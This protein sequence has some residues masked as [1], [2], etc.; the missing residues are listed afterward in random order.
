MA[1]VMA[2]AVAIVGSEEAA[3]AWEEQS[4]VPV[5][6]SGAM[7]SPGDG[8]RA[9]QRPRRRNVPSDP[10]V[11]HRGLCPCS[12]AVPGL[13]R[14]P[15]TSWPLVRPGDSL[16]FLSQPLGVG[17]PFWQPPPGCCRRCWAGRTLRGDVRRRA[18]QE[19]P[20]R[21][22]RV[23]PQRADVK[24][25]L[26]TSGGS[27]E[28][29]QPKPWLPEPRGRY[30]PESWGSRPSQ[31]GWGSGGGGGGAPITPSRQAE[32]TQRANGW[33]S[34]GFPATPRASRCCHL[35]SLVFIF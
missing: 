21:S 14:H 11:S 32:F 10:E 19:G 7:T 4:R 17:S 27:T 34:V 22:A 1:D 6:S 2:V 30:T 35:S 13:P 16:G 23:R 12:G 20:W 15:G 5:L 24:L 28:L 3:G 26:G 8:S 9:V 33:P 18:W 31:Q 25:Q 29:I